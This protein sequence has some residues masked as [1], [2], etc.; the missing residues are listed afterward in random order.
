MVDT[1]ITGVNPDE[2]EALM[3][4]PAPLSNWFFTSKGT[5]GVRLTFCE[6]GASGTPHARAAVLV[7]YSDL[8]TLRDLLDKVIKDSST[9]GLVPN[10]PFG[11]G[12]P[13][14]AGLIN[15]G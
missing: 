13:G 8:V 5:A 14:A 12:P 2:T 7:S 10:P 3:Q 1:T 11:L 4:V 6:K 15:R 9:P